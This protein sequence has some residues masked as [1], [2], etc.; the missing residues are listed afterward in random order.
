MV[1]SLATHHSH[2]PKSASC[3]LCEHHF[4]FY[5][6]IFTLICFCTPSSST[7]HSLFLSKMP[8]LSGLQCNVEL[9]PHNLSLPELDI[10]Y[11]NQ[12]VSCT[13]GVPDDPTTFN[14]HFSARD[15]VGHGIAAF[16]FIDG[17][18]QANRNWTG[19]SIASRP[20]AYPTL[21]VDFRFRQKE[22]LAS[23]G[24]SIIARDWHFS[25]V[26]TGQYPQIRY[27]V[28]H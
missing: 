9:S 10:T 8:S 20:T 25:D 13:V 1:S 4:T 3:F 22:E 28:S 24:R 15:I 16:V 7:S 11:R 23:D 17:Q 14:I 2:K 19:M 12:G 18:Y 6:V 5:T 26:K 21:D 27:V